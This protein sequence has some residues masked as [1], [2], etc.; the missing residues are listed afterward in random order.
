MRF[1]R[2]FKSFATRSECP[3]TL[4]NEETVSVM[5]SLNHRTGETEHTEY[6]ASWM[7]NAHTHTQSD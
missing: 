1:E 5:R 6:L 2:L 7:C 4:S 3:Y